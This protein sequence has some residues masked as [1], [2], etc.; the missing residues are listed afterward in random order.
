MDEYL[1]PTGDAMNVWRKEFKRP[2]GTASEVIFKRHEC[3]W[4]LPQAVAMHIKYN[5]RHLPVVQR[6]PDNEDYYLR[7]AIRR[8]IRGF[9]ALRTY[10]PPSPFHEV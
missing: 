3:E 5:P 2:A 8:T 6:R 9:R 10:F 7:M 4:V 1:Q